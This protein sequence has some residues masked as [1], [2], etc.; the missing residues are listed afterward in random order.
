MLAA[1]REKK[2]T[3]NR[4]NKSIP[5]I[6]C[7]FLFTSARPSVVWLLKPGWAARLVPTTC[8]TA[9][10]AQL[11]LAPHTHTHTHTLSL[12]HTHTRTHA[13]ARARTRA[14][15]H[16]CMMCC[17]LVGA[18]D[19][20]RTP[21]TTLRRTGRAVAAAGQRTRCTHARLG[22]QGRPRQ[23]LGVREAAGDAVSGPSTHGTCSRADRTRT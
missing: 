6:P 22:S 21:A 8:Q 9:S 23:A 11:V 4:L 18:P 19:C 20:S 3:C 12:T 15:E 2:P 17:V 7:V 14:R 5:K 13:H 16:T 1:R 10:V